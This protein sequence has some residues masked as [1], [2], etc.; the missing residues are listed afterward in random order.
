MLQKIP[1]I[2]KP[3]LNFLGNFKCT[4][5]NSLFLVQKCK[6]EI[7]CPTNSWKASRGRARQ[8]HEKHK[9]SCKNKKTLKLIENLADRS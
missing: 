7:V 2:A 3:C 8:V 9:F 6:S 4:I 1:L 5:M